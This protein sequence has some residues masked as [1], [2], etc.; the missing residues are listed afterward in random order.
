MFSEPWE[1]V[2]AVIHFWAEWSTGGVLVLPD[3]NRLFLVTIPDFSVT[4]TGAM[5]SGDRDIAAGL[6]E[7]NGIIKAAG[8]ARGLQVVDVF[9]LSQ[10]MKDDPA[11]VARD[12]L[13]PSAKEYAQWEAMIFPVARRLLVK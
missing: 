9:A 6:T 3:T 11:L 2:K 8:V 5:F 4:P 7:F 13:H 1:F 10:R 12:G